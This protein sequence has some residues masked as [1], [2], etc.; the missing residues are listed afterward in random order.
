MEAAL[1]AQ[2]RFAR[3]P[4]RLEAFRDDLVQQPGDASIRRAR[5]LFETRHV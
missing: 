5:H 4:G 1:V 3:L 2:F